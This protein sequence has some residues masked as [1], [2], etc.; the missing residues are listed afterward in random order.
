MTLLRSNRE[1]SKDR[2]WNWTLPAWRIVLPDGRKFN[3][4][5]NAGPCAQYCYARNGTYLFRNVREAHIRNLMFVLDEPR[6]MDLMV[7]ELS[8]RKFR[9][10]GNARVL[11]D[12]CQVV[13]DEWMRNW[14][15]VGGAAVRVHDSGDFFNEAYL[16][17]WLE[18]A[19]RVPDVLFYAYTKEVSLF[20][21]LKNPPVNFRWL[22]SLGGLEDHLI[23]LST[24]RHADV[25][26]TPEAIVAAGYE[27]QDANDLLCILLDTP[28]VGITA[29][30]IRHFNK[31]MDG[32]R[33]S[34]LHP[35]R[36]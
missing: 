14:L 12:G 34:E 26:P 10:T 16:D 9:P 23:D 25:F 27:S 24:E 19:E 13:D 2:I 5:P 28:K 3:T 6:W 18:V 17:G 8:A 33:F 30:A 22:Y 32:R 1:L 15:S 36:S 31:R 35:H 11:P 29:N 7:E 4:C 20:Q 21:G